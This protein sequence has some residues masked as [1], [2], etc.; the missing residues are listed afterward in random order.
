MQKKL[1]ILSM[2]MIEN[3]YCIHINI[4]IL[5]GIKFSAQIEMF[6]YLYN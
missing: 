4:K 5:K 1:V 6:H 3:E 2:N